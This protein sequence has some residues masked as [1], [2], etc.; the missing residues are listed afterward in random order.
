M[1]IV[2]SITYTAAIAA[3]WTGQRVLLVIGTL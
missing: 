1:L 3:V 2:L